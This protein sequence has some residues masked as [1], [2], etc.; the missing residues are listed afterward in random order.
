MMAGREE[1]STECNQVLFP[2]EQTADADVDGQE[3]KRH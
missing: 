2:Q 1:C 3:K